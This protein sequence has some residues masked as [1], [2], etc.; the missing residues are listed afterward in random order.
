ME[1]NGITEK[2]SSEHGESLNSPVMHEG[3]P[4]RIPIQQLI[5]HTESISL[6]TVALYIIPVN[7]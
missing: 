6:F 1:P 2:Q 7:G 5:K 3:S 4:E